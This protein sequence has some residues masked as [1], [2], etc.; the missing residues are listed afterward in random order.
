[1]RTRALL[2]LFALALPATV[3]A[4]STTR[5]PRNVEQFETS[6]LPAKPASELEREIFNDLRLHKKGDL[7]DA[8]R[9]HAKLAQY[10][11]QS[12]NEALEDVCSAKAMQAWEAATGERPT[13][14]GSQGSPPFEPMN[15]IA[16]S[17]GYK[18]DLSVE[19][20][21]DFFS[22]GTF[23]HAVFSAEQTAG[24]RP[25]ELGWYSIDGKKIRL[26][27]MKPRADRVVGFELLGEGGKDGAVLDG[28]KMGVV[29]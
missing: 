20:T 9:I 29:K 3:A 11:R 13:S 8:T 22:D 4:Q 6:G 19:H 17:F 15:T 12:G 27:Q 26:W 1:M 16:L 21:W 23:A 2:V 24:A 25:R 10:Y 28:V 5:R 18:D 14:A 7:T